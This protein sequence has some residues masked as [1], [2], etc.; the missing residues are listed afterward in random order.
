MTSAR[1]SIFEPSK[2]NFSLNR[3]VIA[4]GLVIIGFITMLL[5]IDINETFRIYYIL[6]TSIIFLYFLIT[7]L[8][9]YQPLKGEIKGELEF[10]LTVIIINK[11]EFKISDLEAIYLHY[12]DYFGERK[13]YVKGN[14]NQNIR[15]G[16][17]NYISFSDSLNLTHTYYFRVNDNEDALKLLP[18]INKYNGAY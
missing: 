1:Y 6:L 15:Q 5:P 7:S 18:F 10:G 12:E 9:A 8:W 17:K 2:D 16:V 13:Y 11:E 14:L 4:Y 3:N